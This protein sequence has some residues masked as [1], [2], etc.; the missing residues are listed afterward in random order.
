MGS[1]HVLKDP[2][3]TLAPCRDKKSILRVNCDSLKTIHWNKRMHMFVLFHPFDSNN[4]F[5]VYDIILIVS[6]RMSGDTMV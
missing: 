3:G 2:S 6:P 1:I 5:S 4:A